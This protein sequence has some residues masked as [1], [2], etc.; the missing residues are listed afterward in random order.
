MPNILDFLELKR[1]LLCSWLPKLSIDCK[2]QPST[3]I[4]GP[5]MW[6]KS[7]GLHSKL[8]S[9]L[10]PYHQ[11]MCVLYHQVQERLYI[12]SRAVLGQ[13]RGTS[14]L[15]SVCISCY[16]YSTVNFS[17]AAFVTPLLLLASRI[18]W[19]F[20]FWEDS[21]PVAFVTVTTISHSQQRWQI[22]KTF[23]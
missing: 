6:R 10:I 16:Y 14:S 12:S 19:P 4:R 17:F 13:T 23:F 7:M 11:G 5:G 3:V 1:P 22:K 18:C 21:C 8:H 15:A 2:K 9:A 20:A